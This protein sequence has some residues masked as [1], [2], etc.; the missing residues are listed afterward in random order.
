MTLIIA[1]ANQEYVIQIADRRLSSNG[2]LVDD[3]SNKSDYLVTDDSQML[4]GFTGLAEFGTFK[5]RRWILDILS[6]SKSNEIREVFE[7]LAENATE[8]FKSDNLLKNI[9]R[10]HKRLSIMFTGFVGPWLIGNCIITNFQDFES[11]IDLPECFDEFRVHPVISNLSTLPEA[12]FVQR[13]GAW[14]A[15]FIHSDL[16]YCA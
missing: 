5:T 3:E 15:M 10:K 16:I 4:F 6:K 13:V 8:Y 9:P 11:F 1:L 2:T 14:G 7:E 12:T